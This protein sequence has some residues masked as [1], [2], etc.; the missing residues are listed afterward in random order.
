MHA[1]LD[2]TPDVPLWDAQHPPEDPTFAAAEFG[3]Y[4]NTPVGGWPTATPAVATP[5]VSGYP[6]PGGGGYPAP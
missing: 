5:T 4:M 6:A 3:F 2:L 1:V